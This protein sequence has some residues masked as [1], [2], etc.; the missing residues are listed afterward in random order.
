MSA[1]KA[2]KELEKQ[3]RKD[4][5]NLVLRLKLAA[6]YREAARTGE[7]VALY[8][9]VAVAYH[10]Q[11]RLA[12]AI[13]VCKSVL[14]IDPSQRET[15]ALLA[16]LDVMRGAA[17]PPPPSGGPEVP[18][19]VGAP[20]EPPPRPPSPS[21]DRRP[22]PSSEFG[23]G[24]GLTPRD[25]ELGV[26]P[27]DELA[28]QAARLREAARATPPPRTSERN[29]DWR[30]S[31]PLLTPTP[32]PEP[33]ALHDVADSQRLSD[34]MPPPLRQLDEPRITRRGI[35]PPPSPVRRPQTPAPADDDDDVM[36]RIADPSSPDIEP[37][38]GVTPA[39]GLVGDDA[40]TTIAPESRLADDAPTTI[41]PELVDDDAIEEV[42]A[43]PE[44][45][46]IDD[47]A[48]TTIADDSGALPAVP[49]LP[50]LVRPPGRNPS[51]HTAPPPRP[52]QSFFERDTRPIAAGAADLLAA[53][54][55]DDEFE[56]LPTPVPVDPAVVLTTDRATLEIP[57]E[58]RPFQRSHRLLDVEAD[59]VD[60]STDRSGERAAAR[61]GDLELD[62]D[63]DDLGPAY[64][65][66]EVDPTNPGDRARTRP[67]AR[68]PA[69]PRVP[70]NPGELELL[71][72]FDRPF[73]DTLSRLG[74][75]GAVIEVPLSI[76][77]DLP[78]EA[79]AELARRMSLR[80]Y[81]PG[82]I[83]LREGDLGEACHVIAHG[84]VRVL[85]RDPLDPRAAPIEVAR[86]GTGALFGEFALLADRRRHA[87]VQ[88]VV[89]CEIYEIPRRLL[90]EL[91][92]T[93]PG[94][95]PVLENFYRE[96]LLATLLSTAPFFKPIPEDRRSELLAVFEPRR[97]DSG[98][99]VVVEG[100]PAG[101]LFLI[102]LG[103]VEITKRVG[104]HRS[105][106]LATLGEGAYFGEMSLLRGGV[107]SATVTAVGPTEL[108]MMKPQDFYAV[109]ARHPI[110]WDEVRREANRRQLET[111]QIV[112]GE[113]PLA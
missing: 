35:T 60:Q 1:K 14:E 97:A 108:A 87:T 9:S 16:E 56:E 49:S 112:T 28:A 48:L 13:A 27:V 59:F 23:P 73:A 46:Q 8:R 7:A 15:Q 75:D 52:P 5:E 20:P 21:L 111:N 61:T 45:R 80:H 85:K 71:R 10:S 42:D 2:I 11:G 81:E 101:G 65:S 53:A 72:A 57:E 99:R 79:L 24:S 38:T 63:D 29:L 95:G 105:V 6:A 44:P 103:S 17:P 89:G 106:L 39:V 33:L 40:M 4:P 37:P 25:D 64:D 98:E 96:R 51:A 84:E 78:E 3:L 102:V 86:L 113:T 12:Q 74:P 66:E 94:V 62:D 26:V 19:L 41:A 100:E 88:A 91:A 70:S 69:E 93:F 32:L 50:P 22:P 83:I 18:S 68:R 55:R 30:R 54:S 76:F 43:A 82:E 110:L 31:V 109:I 58:L 104:E 47:E 34:Q 107:A 92:A 90:R 67:A 77:S 36:T